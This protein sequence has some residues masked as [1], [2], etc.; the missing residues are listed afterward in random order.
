MK[1][2]L[3]QEV[4]EAHGGLPTWDRFNRLIVS[5]TF[6]GW[7]F[8]LKFKGGKRTHRFIISLD[9]PL[10]VIEGFPKPGLQGVFTPESVWIETLE[11]QRVKERFAPREVIQQW[12]HTICW[13]DLDLLYF[14]GYACWNY[15]NT[16]FL[17]AREGFRHVYLSDW[18]KNGESFK[19]LEVVYPDYIHAHSRKQVFYFDQCLRI[20]RFDYD[21]EVFAPWAK[22][23]QYCYDYKNCKGIWIPMQ[24]KVFAR[25]KDATIVP[26]ITLVWIKIK[27][28]HFQ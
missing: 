22:A 18:E 19:R 2:D 17:F 20:R 24:R 10:V 8:K 21:P 3:L 6:G 5:M 13:D 27:Q 15:F 12:P 26:G 23:T 4:I 7:A 16:P 9:Y 11:G 28:L 25:K 1:K 14:A